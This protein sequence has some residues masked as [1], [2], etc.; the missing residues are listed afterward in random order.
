M[1]QGLAAVYDRLMGGALYG[2]FAAV[3]DDAVRRTGVRPGRIVDL[4]C[5]TGAMFPH[6][7]ARAPFVIG[8]DPSEEMLA[9]AA[10]RAGGDPR[11]LLLQAS[12]QEFRIPGQAD[13][14]AA[15]CDV[16]NYLAEP[17]DLAAAFARVKR[18]LRPG[19]CFL[20]DVHAPRHMRERIGDDV[21][22][23]ADEAAAS[24]MRTHWDEERGVLLYEVLLF[25]RCADGRYERREETHAQRAFS[26]AALREE[27]ARAGFRDVAVGWDFAFPAGSAEA[28][29]SAPEVPDGARRLFF[30][31]RA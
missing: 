24:F 30:L 9:L 26:P 15:F 20:F 6:L 31:A 8:I 11:V 16:F 10:A 29:G 7:L 4:G 14:C 19:G 23:D 25:I 12:A 28:D 22:C 18:A 1:Y 17:A 2:R 3:L 5:G 27:L 21:Y 13:W